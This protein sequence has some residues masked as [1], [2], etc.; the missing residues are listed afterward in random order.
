MITKY[1][2]YNYLTDVEKGN[3]IEEILKLSNKTIT[4]YKQQLDYPIHEEFIADIC[5][6]IVTIFS[7]QIFKFIFYRSK[8]ELYITINNDSTQR[9]YYKRFIKEK[10]DVL[11]NEY[12]FSKHFI[13]QCFEDYRT[14]TFLCKF[15]AYINNAIRNI[16]KS[17]IESKN[18]KI[19]YVDDITNIHNLGYVFN[20]NINLTASMLYLTDL[21]LKIF[22]LFTNNTSITKKEIIE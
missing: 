14:Y 6:E 16:Y 9:Q 13:F 11:I 8:E 7:M 20:D 22:T 19:I 2:S 15:K 18:N 3:I 12:I 17:K 4:Y 5:L 1:F 10:Y 21:E